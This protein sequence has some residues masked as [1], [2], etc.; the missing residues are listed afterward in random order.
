MNLEILAQHIFELCADR[1]KGSKEIAGQLLSRIGYVSNTEEIAKEIGKYKNG[2]KG[3]ESVTKVILD[4]LSKPY[5]EPPLLSDGLDLSS[6][7][8]D[9]PFRIK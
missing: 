8:D 4:I 6:F 9:D 1:S 5:F 2:G 7:G 3:L